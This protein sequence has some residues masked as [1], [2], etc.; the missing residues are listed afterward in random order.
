MTE[1]DNNFTRLLSSR[2]MNFLSLLVTS[3][4]FHS[5]GYVSLN[6]ESTTYL[7]EDTDVHRHITV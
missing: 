1:D 5:S 7:V 6:Q 4:V 3:R 2:D